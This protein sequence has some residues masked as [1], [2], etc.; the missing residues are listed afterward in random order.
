[1]KT[2][3]KRVTHRGDFFQEVRKLKQAIQA[4]RK[5]VTRVRVQQVSRGARAKTSGCILCSRRRLGDCR[6]PRRGAL[7]LLSASNFVWLRH[8]DVRRGFEERRAG[9]DMLEAVA[10]IHTRLAGITKNGKTLV[11]VLQR[12]LGFN[13]ERFKWNLARVDE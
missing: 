3:G 11:F 10:R 2:F 13:T 8:R 7:S 12:R 9:G 6:G 4:L 1:M 5:H